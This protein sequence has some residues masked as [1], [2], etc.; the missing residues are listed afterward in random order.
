MARWWIAQAGLFLT[1]FATVA[2]SGPG[3]ID[4]V[5]GQTRYEVARS[6]IEHGDLVIRDPNVWFVVFPGRDGQRY[7][8]YRFP[9]SAAGVIAILAADYSGPV[10]EGR[11]HFYF[12]LVSA[13][14]SAILAVIYAVFFRHLGYGPRASL[15]WAAGGVF[16]TPSWFYGTSTF[17]DILGSTAVV[18]AVAT[19]LA[20]RR[21]HPLAG[22]TVAGLAI[23]LA[24]NCKEP[25]GIFVLPVLAA[26]YDPD[27][28]WRSQWRRQATVI[29]LLALAVAVYLGH[30]LYKFPPESTTAHAE[31]MKNY[32]PF[33][34]GSPEVGLLAMSVSLSAGVPFYNP[35][36]LICLAGLKAWWSR[37]KLFCLSLS[38]AI[39]VFVI[40]IS[41]LTFFKGDTAWGPRYLTP[42]FAILWL[43][44]PAGPR[45]LRKWM[46]VIALGLG[47]VVQ[48][49]GLCID[50]H[51]LYI[52]H[53]LP[54]SFYVNASVLYFHPSISHLVNRPREIVE[55]LANRDQQAECYSPSPSPTFAFPVIDFVEKGPAAVQKY[56][57]LNG[58]RF[59][60]ASFQ[61]LDRWS[62]PVDINRSVVLLIGLAVVGLILQI[63]GTRTPR[64]SDLSHSSR[65]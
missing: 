7:T 24:F 56:H 23:G 19:A 14:A 12:T 16:C 11:R 29:L 4:I 30:D 32:I 20:S 43:F 31:L 18:L 6:L 40:F 44:A 45:L 26:M 10:N 2:L 22:A 51:R 59:W 50:P 58:F 34:S 3:R 46:V 47:L 55:V 28:G 53:G 63:F 38:V 42:I 17:D 21:H 39:A 8:K 13:V 48:M 52:E 9:Q 62:R 5:D 25:L 35:A 60:W 61:Y 33:W 54:S 27:L 41:L 15:L 64:S 1:V 49:S 36:S 57:V 65:L 37:E